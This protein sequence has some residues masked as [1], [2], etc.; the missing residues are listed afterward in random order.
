M[1]EKKE[2]EIYHTIQSN[3]YRGIHLVDQKTKEQK[4][5]E[6]EYKLH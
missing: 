3:P 5:M 1:H 4:K 2:A 6:A